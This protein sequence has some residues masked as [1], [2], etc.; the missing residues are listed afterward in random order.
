MEDLHEHAKQLAAGTTQSD[1]SIKT[2]PSRIGQLQAEDVGMPA[3]LAEHDNA[4]DDLCERIKQLAAG[5]PQRDQSI[6]K[7]PSLVLI[8]IV[9]ELALHLKL[10]SNAQCHVGFL[11]VDPWSINRSGWRL[12][13][14]SSPLPSFHRRPPWTRVRMRKEVIARRPVPGAGARCHAR[15]R[16]AR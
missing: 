14:F 11:I 13:K 7:I 1:Q 4:V 3:Q 12:L 6:K 16:G 9:L 15:S 2:I 10:K 5:A 8:P